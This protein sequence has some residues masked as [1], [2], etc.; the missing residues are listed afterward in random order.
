MLVQNG[1]DTTIQQEY[2]AESSKLPNLVRTP[3][4]DLSAY[5]NQVGGESLRLSKKISSE[6]LNRS[7]I[8]KESLSPIVCP[9]Q[10]SST[11][12]QNPI[13]KLQDIELKQLQD[14]RKLNMGSTPTV[15]KDCNPRAILNI[16][17]PPGSQITAFKF[18]TNKRYS[19]FSN[20]NFSRIEE[21]YKGVM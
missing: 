10:V 1:R 11:K 16:A 20:R 7:Q 14:K 8:V 2:E 21:K 19:K 4:L 15:E 12:L 13:Q 17:S 9:G 3:L 18:Q 6:A 5:T